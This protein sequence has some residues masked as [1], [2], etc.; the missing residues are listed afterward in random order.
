MNSLLSQSGDSAGPEQ[1]VQI[2]Q[3]FICS[4]LLS[5]VRVLL[6]TTNQICIIW[7][8]N[9][10]CSSETKPTEVLEQSTNS[11]NMVEGN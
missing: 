6:T 1:A 3:R 11:I 8:E 4:Y 7:R 10:I 2:Q 9:S 5:Q